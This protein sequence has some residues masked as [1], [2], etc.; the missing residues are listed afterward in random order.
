VSSRRRTPSGPACSGGSCNSVILPGFPQSPLLTLLPVSV[1]FTSCFSD[2]SAQLLL[3]C[4]WPSGHTAPGFLSAVPS[5]LSYSLMLVYGS[6]ASVLI[7]SSSNRPSASSSLF[8]NLHD[9]PI[10]TATFHTTEYFHTSWNKSLVST[11]NF[12]TTTWFNTWI[13]PGGEHGCVY[14]EVFTAV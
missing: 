2:Q 9:P 10:I 13:I 4:W 6:P 7:K 1:G 11:D 12:L 14:G 8:Y 5:S 3:V